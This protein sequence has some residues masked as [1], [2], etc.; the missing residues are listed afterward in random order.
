MITFGLLLSMVVEKSPNVTPADW[1]RDDGINPLPDLMLG[2]CNDWWL[3][4]HEDGYLYVQ[5]RYHKLDK[6][7]LAEKAWRLLD[8][9]GEIEKRYGVVIKLPWTAVEIDIAYGS[10]VRWELSI[11]DAVRADA[12]KEC[13]ELVQLRK[14]LLKTTK[15]LEKLAALYSMPAG[16]KFLHPVWDEAH[17]VLAEINNLKGIKQNDSKTIS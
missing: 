14:L 4:T 5:C 17:A 11:K 3:K 9:V 2:T 7:A 1:E 12:V 16:D 10:W 15:A 6:G 8:V 13:V